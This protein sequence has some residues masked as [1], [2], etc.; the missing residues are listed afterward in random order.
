MDLLDWDEIY[1]EI[2]SYKVTQGYFNL[3]IQKHT[4]FDLMNRREY[5][6]YALPEQTRFESYSDLMKIHQIVLMVLKDY[7]DRFYNARLQRA[8]ANALRISHLM[9][10]HENLSFK[11]YS[12]R[13]PKEEEDI[14]IKK[15]R[16]LLRQAQK[17]YKDDTSEI[18]SIHFD[19]HLYTPLVVYS[20]GKDFVKCSPPRLN[21]G[22]TQFVRKLR[23]YAMANRKQFAKKQLFLLRNLSK[24]GVRFF[25]SSGFYPDFIMWLRDGKKTTVAFID[26]KGIL[27]SGNFGNEKIQLFKRIKKLE[28]KLG[29]PSLRLESFILSV[30]KYA[31]VRKTF[32][33]GRR[34][35]DEFTANHV[36]FLDEPDILSELMTILL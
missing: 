5:Q 15:I 20:K 13:I 24:K 16:K 9:Q 31:T 1:S 27:N 17:L 4:L 2:L 11:T 10:D 14:E 6:V 29:D 8:E 21:E 19:R 18:P 32:D 25:Q 33:K 7:M 28:T 23:D 12:L 22:E 36:L 26:P 3:A 34:H 35:K 30:S